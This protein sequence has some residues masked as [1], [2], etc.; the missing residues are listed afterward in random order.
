M[1]KILAYTVSILVAFLIIRQLY[2]YFTKDKIIEGATGDSTSDDDVTEYKDPDM[3]QDP[4]Y[5]ATLNAANIAWLK[6]QL[7][8]INDLSTKIDTIDKQVESNS[9]TVQSLS[10]AI[11]APADDIPDDQTTADLAATGNTTA[12]GAE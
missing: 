10:E 6:S 11:S 4:L 3:S 7:D 1:E 12:P 9:A 5:L 8:T 2:Y